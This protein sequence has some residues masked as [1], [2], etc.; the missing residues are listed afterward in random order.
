MKHLLLLATLGITGCATLTTDPQQ[1][2][3]AE[4]MQVFPCEGGFKWVDVRAPG[5]DLTHCVPCAK[6]HHVS[7]RFICHGW[8]LKP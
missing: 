1:D 2:F 6:A 4:G 5:R 7:E 8:R 3:T